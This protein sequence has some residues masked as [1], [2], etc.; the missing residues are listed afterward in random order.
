MINFGKNLKIALKYRNITSKNLAKKIGVKPNTISNYITGV[1]SPSFEVLYAILEELNLSSD[2]LLFKDFEQDT[3]PLKMTTKAVKYH[4]EGGGRVLR[5]D[6]LSN[7]Y[8]EL[9]ED[10]IALNN[11]ILSRQKRVIPQLNIQKM[12]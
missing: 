11:K 1:S 5:E 2:D 12:Q 8:Y 4:I 3:T 6:E 7:A 9:F 10:F